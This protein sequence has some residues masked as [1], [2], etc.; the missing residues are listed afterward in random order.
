M[1][2]NVSEPENS[3]TT[4]CAEFEYL[5]P[6]K[7]GPSVYCKERGQVRLGNAQADYPSNQFRLM[8]GYRIDRQ[9]QRDNQELFVRIRN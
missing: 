6:A 7:T 8:F 5:G 4:V 3:R 2:P 9:H 1:P